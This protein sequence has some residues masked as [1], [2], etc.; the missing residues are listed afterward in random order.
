MTNHVAPDLVAAV[1][2]VV[3][4]F[5]RLA[6]LI[7][8]LE[9]TRVNHNGPIYVMLDHPRPG[10]PNELSECAEVRSWVGAWKQGQTNV[11]VKE[12]EVNLGV[13]RAM[14]A[15]IDWV[16]SEGHESVIVLEED[17]LPAPDFFGFMDAMLKRFADDERVMMVSGDQFVPEPMVRTLESSYYFSRYIHI[18]GWATWKR[19]WRHYDHDMNQLD[20]PLLKTDLRALFPRDAEAK[21]FGKIWAGQRGN[22]DDTAWASRWMLAC[23]AQSGL[24]VCPSANLVRNI[25]FDSDSTHTRYASRYQVAGLDRLHEPLKDP[26]SVLPWRLGDEWWFDHMISKHPFARVRR[27]ILKVDPTVV[28]DRVSPTAVPDGTESSKEGSS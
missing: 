3:I 9:A 15:A 6:P 27:R 12:M 21:T 17:C 1:P 14:P 11:V 8:V 13:S 5:K 19:A 26:A 24:C 23:L 25:G 4:G 18:W 20:D 2:V 28:P 7:R 22:D 10:R 16:F